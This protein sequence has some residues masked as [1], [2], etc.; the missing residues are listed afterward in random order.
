MKGPIKFDFS[1][2]TAAIFAIPA[3]QEPKGPAR[4]AEPQELK[5][6]NAEAPLDEARP[7]NRRIAE[8]ASEEKG[9]SSISEEAITQVRSWLHSIGETDQ[10]IIDEVL[11]Y[12]RTHPEGLVYYLKRAEELPEDNRHYCRDCL[13]LRN[14]YCTR[15]RFRPVD[16]LP[17]RCDKF[18]H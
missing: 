8:I 13:N 15:Q 14:G 7:Q 3:I 4:T 2:Y 16:D 6:K 12:C 1:S 17:R 9:K 5:T 10:A 11:D 18:A